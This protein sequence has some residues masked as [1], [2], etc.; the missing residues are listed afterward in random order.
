MHSNRM[1][2]ACPSPY[3]GV[4]L[5]ETPPGRKMGS[6]TVTPKRNMGP[7][8]KAGSDIIKVAEFPKLMINLVD[9]VNKQYITYL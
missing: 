7:S 6:E 2:T 8:S 9:Y 3:R 1:H 5:T 4:S